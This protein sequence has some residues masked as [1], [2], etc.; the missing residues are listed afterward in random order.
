MAALEARGYAVRRAAPF[1][2]LEFKA[3]KLIAEMRNDL[4][5][6]PLVRQF[7]LLSRRVTYNPGATPFF[8]YFHEDHDY[9]LSVMTI[10]E[11]AGAIHDI[12]FNDVPRYNFTAD[13]VS[14]LIEG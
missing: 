9:L 13:F 3:P 1:P 14:F 10:M 2:D 8:K 5:R 11:H 7:I 12:A 4:T 6:E